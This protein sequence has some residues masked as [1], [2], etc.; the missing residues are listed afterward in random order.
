MPLLGA[1]VIIGAGFAAGVT[2]RVGGVAGLVVVGVGIA[3]GV[4]ARVGGMMSFFVVNAECRVA[5]SDG[6]A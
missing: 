1:W 2:A 5:G 4:T 6:V 3:V